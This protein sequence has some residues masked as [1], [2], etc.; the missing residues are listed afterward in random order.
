M[1][2]IEMTQNWQK[3]HPWIAGFNYVPSYAVNSTEMWQINSFDEKII[4]RELQTAEKAGYNAC[5]VFL[6]FILWE[7]E[8]NTF[9]KNLEVFLG[10]AEKCGLQVV[11]ILFD[12]CAFSNLE[13]YL[14]RQKD[15][16]LGIHNSGWTPSPGFK[17]ADDPS[18]LPELENYVKEIIEIYAHD[19]RIL[20]WDL[21]NEPGNSD[22]REKCLPLLHSV[23][24]WAREI[25]P[26]QP[27]TAGVW[28]W[29]SYDLEALELSDIISY[30]DYLGLAET[31]ARVEPFLKDGRPVYCTEWLHRQNNNNF[32]THLPYYRKNHIGVFQWGLVVGR[33]Q[34]N[35]NWIPDLNCYNGQPEIW[36]HDVFTSDLQPYCQAEL[37]LLKQLRQPDDSPSVELKLPVTPMTRPVM[38][39]LHELGLITLMS[40]GRHRIPIGEEEGIGQDI[41]V[42]EPVSGPHKLITVAVSRNEFSAF[43]YHDQNEE[44]ILLGG[45]GER[46]LDLLVCYLT[47][48]E[49]REKLK[50][51]TVNASDFVCLRC[52]FNDPEVSFFTMHAGVP[53][54]E[55]AG[56]GPGMPATFYVTESEKTK[57]LPIPL[58][59]VSRK[60]EE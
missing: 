30:H 48:E 50:N 38:E 26:S 58:G 43:G 13:P 35:L 23:F 25:G 5:R 37:D 51:G 39:H 33:T 53:H 15:P 42:S 49:L 9:M 31:K 36:Q 45:E 29:E 56:P 10:L 11:P 2:S 54:G 27:L 57:L 40:P 8:H 16:V 3:K 34:T 55:A 24:A 4:T 59:I 32:S 1:W 46:P 41:Y 12:D 17:I 18:A 47:K 21:Y 52:K 6:P 19:S 7:N 20:F 14:G 22:R 44:F 60:E 28:A